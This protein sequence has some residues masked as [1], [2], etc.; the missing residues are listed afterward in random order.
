M[1]RP[2]RLAEKVALITGGA[3]GQGAEEGRLF[4][5]A[6]NTAV[7]MCGRAEP[8]RIL[9]SERVRDEARSLAARFQPVGREPLKGLRQPVSLFQVEWRDDDSREKGTP[10]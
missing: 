8:G 6:V 10:R 2:G 4:G 9:A 3:R 5:T 7:R 1:T